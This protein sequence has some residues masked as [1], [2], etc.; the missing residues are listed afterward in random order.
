[1]INT[2]QFNWNEYLNNKETLKFIAHI[3]DA[4][5]LDLGIGI[6]KID[7][8][9]DFK[10][11]FKDF[12]K[13]S[14]SFEYWF[15]DPDFNINQMN[16][17]IDRINK[18]IDQIDYMLPTAEANKSNLALDEARSYWAGEFSDDNLINLKDFYINREFG[19]IQCSQ[20]WEDF[21]DDEEEKFILKWAET[22]YVKEFY[23]RFGEDYNKVLAKHFG[24][25]FDDAIECFKEHRNQFEDDGLIY[26]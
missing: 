7:K 21:D 1:M 13:E 20:C 8:V 5:E 14:N 26:I 17:N 24:T 19:M 2:E 10:I 11:K 15:C 18:C 22:E 16:F 25:E 6:K 12:I 3:D 23:N 4:F 9:Y